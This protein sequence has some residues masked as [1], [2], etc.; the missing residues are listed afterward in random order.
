M[1]LGTTVLMGS[2]CA[3]SESLEDEYFKTRDGYIQKLSTVIPPNDAFVDDKSELA[4][5]EQQ[6]KKIL[7]SV[8]VEGF[9]GNGEINL[10]ALTEQLGFGKLDGL[11]FRSTDTTLVVTNTRLLDR[12]IR[13]GKYTTKNLAEV[14]ANEEFYSAG[15]F[16]ESAASLYAPVPLVKRNKRDESYAYLGL[17]AQDIGPFLPYHLFVLTKRNDKVFIAITQLTERAPEFE[18]CQKAWFDKE[19]KD[20]EAAYSAYKECY[21]KNIRETEFYK[22][23][24]KQADDIVKRIYQ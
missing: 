4:T 8:K 23:V 13:D 22:D 2:V 12:Y 5:L 7:G 24:S 11:V 1:L 6:L 20:E 15:I 16:S 14:S 10:D 18:A 3:N 21:G 19:K 9:D 17:H